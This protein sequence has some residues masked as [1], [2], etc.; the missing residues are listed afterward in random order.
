MLENLKL[1]QKNNQQNDHYPL[2]IL[3][4]LF[5]AMMNVFLVGVYL[6]LSIIVIDVIKNKIIIVPRQMVALFFFAVSY[7]MVVVVQGTNIISAVKIFICPFVWMCF[8]RFANNKSLHSIAKLIL[9]MALGMA[10]HGV[11]NFAYNSVM[12]VDLTKGE[13]YDIWSRKLSSTTGQAVN[14]TLFVAVFFWILNFKK[15]SL[16]VPSIIL[17]VFALLYD[18]NLGGR[19]FLILIFV[20][21]VLYLIMYMFLGGINIKNIGKWVFIFSIVAVVLIAIIYMYNNNIFGL[22]DWYRDSY[23]FDR[24][25]NQD[26]ANIK[27]NSRFERK[28]LY[29]VNA[30]KYLFG[31]NYL[32]NK[33]GIGHAHDLW[34]DAYD[35]AGIVPCVFLVYYTIVSIKRFLTVAFSKRLTVSYRILFLSIVVVLMLQFFVE[36]ILAGAPLL[37]YSYLI[38]DASLASYLDKNYLNKV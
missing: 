38:I 12:G 11:L 7:F 31:G 28:R 2:I 6:I 20:S 19:T 24:L 15:T 13:G 1:L 23:L 29:I 32:S 25:T 27:G 22:K 4:I 9:V 5:C 17:M 14:F 18:I 10:I 3:I 33:E 8:Y 16:V 35:E 26:G 37:F 36:P 21:F 30:H 34:L